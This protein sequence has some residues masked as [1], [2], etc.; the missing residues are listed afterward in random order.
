VKGFLRINHAYL[1]AIALVLS[2]LAI[3]I[4]STDDGVRFVLGESTLAIF[5]LVVI[6]SI[7]VGLYFYINNEK[8]SDLTEQIKELSQKEK[9]GMEGLL[10][11]LTE[12]QREVYDMIVSGRSNKEIMAELFIE[13]NTLKSHINQIYR[14]L[15]ITSR[16]DLKSKNRAG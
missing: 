7:L 10:N 15:E 12:R 5:L 8:I 2:S 14:K 13:K 1:L 3:S 11:N 4:R 16:R 9:E 6:S